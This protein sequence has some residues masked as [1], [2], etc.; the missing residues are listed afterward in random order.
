MFNRHFSPKY[1]VPD[2]REVGEAKGNHCCLSVASPAEPWVRTEGAGFLT[3][4]QEALLTREKEA[5]KAP[6]MYSFN[7]QMQGPR[8]TVSPLLPTN[9]GP[10]VPTNLCNAHTQLRCLGSPLTGA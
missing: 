4:P 1:G 5:G 10:Q 7:E 9:D 2:G 3:G 8:A 6:L